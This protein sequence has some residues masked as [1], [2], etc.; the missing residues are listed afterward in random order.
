M[1]SAKQAREKTE[2]SR[3]SLTRASVEKAIKKA[4]ENGRDY[5]RLTTSINKELEAELAENGFK[6]EKMNGLTKISW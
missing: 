3:L 5:I 1:I 4:I 6:I 2:S